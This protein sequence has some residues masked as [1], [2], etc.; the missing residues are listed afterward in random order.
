MINKIISVV[1]IALICSC[2]PLIAQ[3]EIK[4]DN[5]NEMILEYSEQQMR[6]E[7]IK[8]YPKNNLGAS[9]KTLKL[10]NQQNNTPNNSNPNEEAIRLKIAYLQEIECCESEINA[11]QELLNH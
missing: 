7:K 8:L 1:F 11:L 3:S 9:Y 5:S 4:Q 6:T 2:S 10:T